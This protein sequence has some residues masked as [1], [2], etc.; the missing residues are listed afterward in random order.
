METEKRLWL[1]L[2]LSVVVI[3]GYSLWMQRY[4][5]VARPSG[6]V[7]GQTRS[8]ESSGVASGRRVFLPEPTSGASSSRRPA[9]PRAKGVEIAIENENVKAIVSTAGGRIVSWRLKDYL[10]TGTTRYEELVPLRA[11]RLGLRGGNEGPLCV[12]LSDFPESV[13]WPA[14]ANL[15][16]LKVGSDGIEQCMPGKKGETVMLPSSA[17]VAPVGEL[18]L[19]QELPK[20]RILTKRLYLPATGYLARLVIELSGPLPE[21]L[22]IMWYPG[23]GYSPNEEEFLGIQ[24][25]FWNVSGLKLLNRSDRHKVAESKE[26]VQKE[27]PNPFWVAA[28]NKYFTAAMLP[29]ST[30]ETEGVEEVL[31]RMVS[32][33]TF[34]TKGGITGFFSREALR[35]DNMMAVLKFKLKPGG[36]QVRIV[37][38]VYLG[39]MNYDFL[40]AIEARLE[41]VIDLGF[42]GFIALPMMQFLKFLND[43]VVHN[44][45]MAIILLTVLIKAI[46]WMP[47]QWGMNQ[48]KKLKDVQPQMKFITEQFKDDAK[49]KQEEMMRLYRDNKVNPVGGCLPLL[50]QI[51]IFFA[52]YTVLRTAV[53]LRGAPFI[54]WITDLS[55]KDPYYVLPAL[56]G[57]TMWLQQKMTPAMGDPAQQKM[58]RWMSLF[59]V[60]IFLNMPSGFMLYFLVQNLTQIGQQ[61]HTNRQPSR[62]PTGGT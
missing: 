59:F 9:A 36:R 5:P 13:A 58:M 25:T 47:S 29:V 53:E 20:G 14:T 42:F 34:E 32:S 7:S 41:K 48:M 23:V 39:P 10:A 6:T 50:L 49:R 46:L 31:G 3:V 37:T 16:E 15:S 55:T 30:D 56:V 17:G 1:A 51:P 60:L 62:S 24:K 12:R 22:E 54:L 38:D 11:E 8:M 44:Y 19:K 2:G 52:L 45:G 4:A 40:T 33:G 61:L 57:V 21:S 18:V 28:H 26:A 43:S 35:P 27:E